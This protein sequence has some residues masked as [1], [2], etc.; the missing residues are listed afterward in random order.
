M[1]VHDPVLVVVV[2]DDGGLESGEIL[3]HPGLRQLAQGFQRY[4]IG[5]IWA[6]D[7]V[8]VGAGGL[9]L[10]GGV[11]SERDARE[12]HLVGPS[13]E[14]AGVLG[15]PIEVHQVDRERAAALG[16]VPFDPGATRMPADWLDD[17]HR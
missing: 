14:P 4:L 1:G 11:V 9:A 16:E 10:P 13:P 8:L 3:D 17:G 7:V 5:G 12:V 15:G 6:H 2:V